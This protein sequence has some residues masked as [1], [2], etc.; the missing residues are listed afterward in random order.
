MVRI[1]LHSAD[2]VYNSATKKYTFELDKRIDR[3]VRISVQKAHYSAATAAE[4][5]L[6]VYLRSDALS[7]LI[8]SKH[9]IRLKNNN[10]EQTE[11][12]LA[13]LSETHKM[14]RYALEN[15][16]RTFPAD[17]YRHLRTIDV[18]FTTND[19]S[20]DA[21]A[22]TG[23]TGGATNAAVTDADIEAI[24][25]DLLLWW[26]FD[27]SRVL[28][29]TF[30]P[31]STVGSS[32]LYYY[33]RSPAPQGLLFVNAYGNG[34]QLANCGSAKGVTRDGS[35][36]SVAD[37]SSNNNPPQDEEWTLHSLLTMPS[38]MGAVVELFL[39]GSK[40][41][42]ITTTGTGGI[43]IRD[44]NNSTLMISNLSYIPLRSYILSVQR[45]VGTA[46]HGNGASDNN[47]GFD[48]Y[49]FHWR[50]EDLST[51]TV[52][53][54]ISARGAARPAGGL[55]TWQFGRSTTH[56]D[57]VQ[58]CCI[59]YNG[60]DTTHYNNSISWLKSK[61]AG[62]STDNSGS[63]ETSSASEDAKW[64]LELDIKQEVK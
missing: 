5:P 21:T 9:T 29:S 60:T 59:A 17:P 13:S 2:A 23:G 20:M 62:E 1:L 32:C 36:E 47:N 42:W 45:R 37:A 12:I 63:Q 8:Q 57:Q 14:G 41:L 6:V 49:E 46:D 22:A 24:G 4:Y 48:D 3:P 51:N 34:L 16:S 58:S 44:R 53:T 64:F 15:D 11:N 31:V 38:T 43:K 25:S 7:S 55:N 56:F 27:P 61:F 10:H 35:W 52:Q 19:S 39:H 50:L 54:D 40:Y 33:N 18:F 26:D 30:Q 28:D